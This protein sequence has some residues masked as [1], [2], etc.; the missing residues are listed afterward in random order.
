MID[1][2]CVLGRER[3]R[4]GTLG[5]CTGGDRSV[6]RE[7]VLQREREREREREGEGE[8]ERE[9]FASEHS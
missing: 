7:C 2:L 5:V 3:W 8:R 4:D 6:E 9:N 1:N